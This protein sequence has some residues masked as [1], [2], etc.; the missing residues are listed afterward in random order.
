VFEV[1]HSERVNASVERLWALWADPSRWSEWD[2][3]IDRADSDGELEPGAEIRVKLHKG[4]TTTHVVVALDPGRCL[5]TEYGLP[6]ALAGH[7]HA[8]AP[9]SGF[10]EVTH[11]LYVEGPLAGFWALML[12]RRRLRDAAG[13]FSERELV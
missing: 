4:G 6:G 13:G 2:P 10:V 12:G 9:R 11:R 3:R 5:V 7:E 8:L 1:E